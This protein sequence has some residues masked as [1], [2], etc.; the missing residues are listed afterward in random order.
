MLILTLSLI[1]SGR[2]FVKLVKEELSRERMP[3]RTPCLVFGSSIRI[4]NSSFGS[5]CV[6]VSMRSGSI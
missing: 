2:E 5:I 3:W 1:F 6:P 4:E